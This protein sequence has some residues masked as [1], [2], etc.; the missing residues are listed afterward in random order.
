MQKYELL[1][2]NSKNNPDKQDLWHYFNIL[3]PKHQSHS[4]NY[5]SCMLNKERL[6]SKSS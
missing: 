3:D 2:N 5:N 6:I 1:A 4:R